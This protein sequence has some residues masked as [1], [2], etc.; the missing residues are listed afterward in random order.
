MPSRHVF[1]G[2]TDRQ[3]LLHSDRLLR[4]RHGRDPTDP[5]AAGSRYQAGGREQQR[6]RGES[7]RSGLCRDTTVVASHTTSSEANS[8]AHGNR[9]ADGLALR[10]SKL[11]PKPAGSGKGSGSTATHAATTAARTHA[12]GTI[13]GT[14]CPAPALARAVWQKLQPAAKAQEGQQGQRAAAAQE[15]AAAEAEEQ[16]AAAES[17]PP[18]QEEE[19]AKE[20]AEAKGWSPELAEASPQAEPWL[21][22]GDPSMEEK[23]ELPPVPSFNMM[24]FGA[25]KVSSLEASPRL[26]GGMASNGPPDVLEVSL[27]TAGGEGDWY[28]QSELQAILKVAWLDGWMA[29][30]SSLATSSL[31][32]ASVATSSLEE[33]SV[34]TSS[35]AGGRP[36]CYKNVLRQCT[37]SN[38]SEQHRNKLRPSPDSTVGMARNGPPEVLEVSP[39][40]AGGMR[41][42]A[43][44]TEP[45]APPTSRRL[46]W[47]DLDECLTHVDKRSL[48]T[49]AIWPPLHEA[50]QQKKRYRGRKKKKPG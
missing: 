27:E 47:V 37:V 46:H 2:L 26:A 39:D 44:L 31:Q 21:L 12:P 19:A 29:G 22:G 40:M 9:I 48:E 34:A 45:P 41:A 11:L 24:V 16:W 49:E 20:A 7:P 23:E 38:P 30:R 5:G 1:R 10:A 42:G 15:A 33:A 6:E 4:Q 13:C 36:Q 3:Q 28:A 32:E 35:L 8:F 14:D 50:P 43:G 17:Q 25:E 18:E